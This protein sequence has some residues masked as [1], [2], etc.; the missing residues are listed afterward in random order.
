MEDKNNNDKDF[1]KMIEN[2]F[3][4]MFPNDNNIDEER[5]SF[6]DE[7]L[8]QDNITYQSSTF[9]TENGGKITISSGFN[10][11][12]HDYKRTPKTTKEKIENLNKILENFIINEEYEKAA[13]T[14]DLIISLEKEL[15]DENNKSKDI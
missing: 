11:L 6:F 5:K 13:D 12:N 9:S 1:K 2:F 4:M 10:D 15:I 7:I 14:R 8:K 3:K